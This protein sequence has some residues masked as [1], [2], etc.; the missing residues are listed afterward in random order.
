MWL[1]AGYEF[2]VAA[3]CWNNL[4]CQVDPVAARI[5]TPDVPPPSVTLTREAL[6]R[7]LEFLMGECSVLYVPFCQQQVIDRQLRRIPP[8]KLQDIAIPSLEQ[9]WFSE[10]KISIMDMPDTETPEQSRDLI[11][12]LGTD[13]AEK[14][15]DDK[16]SSSA[17]KVRP[18]A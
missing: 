11:E 17:S 9:N 7:A 16:S 8:W 14:E 1:C 12:W 4:Q 13:D 6:L 2:R 5:S 3:V 10:E 15:S 18:S